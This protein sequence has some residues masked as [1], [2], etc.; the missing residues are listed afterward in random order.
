MFNKILNHFGYFQIDQLQIG[1]H[2]GICGKPISDKI[3][4]KV[5][6]WGLC[7]ECEKNSKEI[8]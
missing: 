5:W 7:G 6:S 8:I 4:D 3:F 1:G 2:C